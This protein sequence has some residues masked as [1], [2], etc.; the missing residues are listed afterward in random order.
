MILSLQ[1]APHDF[2]RVDIEEE[3]LYLPIRTDPNILPLKPAAVITRDWGSIE[4][5][6]CGDRIDIEIRPRIVAKGVVVAKAS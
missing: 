5:H 3:V 1:R 2:I 4:I 6:A